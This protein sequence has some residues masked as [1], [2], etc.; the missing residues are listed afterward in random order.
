[1]EVA[2]E[3]LIRYWD[4]LRTWIN[5]NRSNLLFYEQLR[6]DASDWDH[7]GR[8]ESYLYRDKR[9]TEAQQWAKTNLS[10]LRPLEKEFLNA[11]Q[12]RR[13][14]ERRTV[15]L[16]RV[17]LGIAVASIAIVIF[18]AMAFGV[19]RITDWMNITV[20]R[21][22]KMEWVE[23]PAG[24]FIMGSE[25][26]E[27]ELPVHT[28][29]L[30]SFEIGEFEVTNEQYL[31]CVKAEI[32]SLPRN[33][34]Y[35]LAEYSK[36]PVTDIDWAEA[37]KFCEWTDPHGYLPT[38]AQ[39]E[40]AARGTEGYTYPWGE[41]IDCDHANYLECVGDTTPVGSYEEGKSPYGAYDMAGNVW[42]WVAD[43]YD[44]DYYKTFM[45]HPLP[46]PTGAE[47]TLVHVQRG[48]SWQ[49]HRS[50]ARSAYRE[51]NEVFAVGFRC[52]RSMG[53]GD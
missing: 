42:E 18:F 3:A 7:S 5:I 22:L 27:N 12:S 49:R 14:R 46:N 33:A 40:K 34:I 8:D 23:V 32:C 16:R 30:D 43:W 31:Q 25:S 4:R 9:L 15:L 13:N 39:W 1:M 28:V 37:G 53:D 17:S 47:H 10:M 36:H 50:F 45:D 51:V 48:G 2:H 24:E 44:K 52:A 11:C 29:Y 20:Y 38:E 26:E 19:R 41:G 35:D 21:P 6:D